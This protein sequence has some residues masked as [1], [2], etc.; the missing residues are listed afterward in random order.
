MVCPQDSS[1]RRLD[2]HHRGNQDVP[3]G[4]SATEG[5]KIHLTSAVVAEEPQCC[6]VAAA[7]PGLDIH[8]VEGIHPAAPV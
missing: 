2:Q 5:N 8:L 6:M 4:E 3:A 1:R 7:R